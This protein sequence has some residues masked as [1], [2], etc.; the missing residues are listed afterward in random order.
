MSE[1]IVADGGAAT[2]KK[3]LV[4]GSVAVL[5]MA[6]LA[7]LSY[8]FS[9]YLN[10]TVLVKRDKAATVVKTPEAN[11]DRAVAAVKVPVV[12]ISYFDLKN[13]DLKVATNSGGNWS[14]ARIDSNG[15]VGQDTSIA[16]DSKGKIH[17]AYYDD[18]PRGDLKYAT[19]VSG[20]WI[21]TTVDATGNVGWYASIVLDKNDKVHI[22]YLDNTN[23]DLKYAK[24]V[25]GTWVTEVVDKGLTSRDIPGRY[26]SLALGNDGVAH[27]GYQYLRNGELGTL[28]YATNVGG[29]WTSV[30]ADAE[31]GAGFGVSA[32][33]D[34]M[35]KMHMTYLGSSRA[36][37]ANNVSG[38]WAITPI[39]S[40]IIRGN[41]TIGFNTSL[42][43]DGA[44]KPTSCFVYALN[45][46]KYQLKCVS[47]DGGKWGEIALLGEGKAGQ[48]NSLGIDDKGKLYVSYYDA[49]RKTLEFATN[50]SGVWSSKTVD[51]DAPTGTWTSLAVS[52]EYVV[53]PTPPLPYS[54]YEKP[55][56]P[57]PY[58]PYEKPKGDPT[59]IPETP[60]P[61]ANPGITLECPPPYVDV[62]GDG[63]LTEDDARLVTN[64][65]NGSRTPVLATGATWQNQNNP[66]DVT[67][68]GTIAPIDTLNV[69]NAVNSKGV[70]KIG[71]KECGPPQPYAGN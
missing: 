35:G 71:P 31:L 15:N 67:N 27:I 48:F 57:L 16:V 42:V 23:R 41:K 63:S 22:A 19:N 40:K 53:P 12:N 64:Y 68:D 10:T 11:R 8:A 49:S 56:P 46:S 60:E 14:S 65:L 38:K 36:K 30:V 2:K 39:D 61:T 54:P 55:T 69:V 7:T 6:S 1:E 5:L 44:N 3:A 18:T 66:V 29:K 28:R 70:G 13:A 20:N 45:L 47:L 43:L 50:S 59:P 37:Y 52:Y 34:P 33:V 51:G 9:R 21:T 24:N 4:V 62:N 17:I 25:S 26:L 58:S 32:K